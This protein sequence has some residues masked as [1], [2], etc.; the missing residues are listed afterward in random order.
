MV[1][2][3]RRINELYAAIKISQH[4]PL[5]TLIAILIT[6]VTHSSSSS[7]SSKTTTTKEIQ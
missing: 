2:T 1:P 3:D 4:L 5:F 7:S 6:L